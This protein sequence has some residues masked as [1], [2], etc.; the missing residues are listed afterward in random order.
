MPVRRSN[1]AWVVTF[2]CLR[3]IV[4]LCVQG[5]ARR[6]LP[7]ADRVLV[8]KMIPKTQTTGGIFLPESN[9]QKN[10]EAEVSRRAARARAS[11]ARGDDDVW[12]AFLVLIDRE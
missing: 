11:D 2:V 12:S 5:I 8:K 6:L 9:S 4:A 3:A 10:N 7:L 1:C